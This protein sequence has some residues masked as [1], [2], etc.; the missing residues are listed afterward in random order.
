MQEADFAFDIVVVENDAAQGSQ[1]I[2]ASLI[3]EAKENGV[4]LRYYCEPEQ[5]ISV[6]RNRCAEECR[7]EFLAFIDDDEW[8]EPDWIQKMMDAQRET[9][10]DVVCGYVRP[11][12]PEGFPEYLKS[13]CDENTSSDLIVPIQR[14]ATGAVV[15][16]KQLLTLR[17]PLFD[18]NFGRTGG[19]DTELSFLFD[20]K[21]IKMVRTYV[22]IV[23]EL[24]PLQRGR[25]MYYW[26]R[27]YRTGINLTRIYYKYFYRMNGTKVFI[28]S[29]L[30][31]FGLSFS[32][33]PYLVIKPRWA[34]ARMGYY[35]SICLGMLAYFGGIKKIGYK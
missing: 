15:L 32:K 5:N 19:E 20:A 22:P 16:R 29:F 11:V 35:A 31:Y 23:Y 33:I 10:A 21:G 30:W 8:A 24:Q 18:L 9:E 4:E 25:M 6:A 27:A 1:A 26:G 13:F 14:F 17:T 2:I 28:R 7:G 34:I 12:Y 3:P